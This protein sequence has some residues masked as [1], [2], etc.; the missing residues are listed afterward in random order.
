MVLAPWGKHQ[1]V[2]DGADA[3]CKGCSYPCSISKLFQVIMLMV[4]SPPWDTNKNTHSSFCLVL[5]AWFFKRVLYHNAVWIQIRDFSTFAGSSW[6][7]TMLP[8]GSVGS[9]KIHYAVCRYLRYWDLW[10]TSRHLNPIL[11]GSAGLPKLPLGCKNL[12]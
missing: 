6:H 1:N 5:R 8:N 7:K 2:W 9:F 11:H 12:N 4:I 3:D 10:Q